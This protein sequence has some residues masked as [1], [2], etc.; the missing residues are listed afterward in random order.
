MKNFYIKTHGCKSNQLES[1]VITEKLIEVGYC[2]T[3][4]IDTADIY[5]LNSCS[6]TETADIEALR[7]IRHIKSLNP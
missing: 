3:T 5:I 1:A 2:K 7:T 4:G 6:V